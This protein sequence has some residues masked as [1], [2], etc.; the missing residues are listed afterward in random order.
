MPAYPTPQTGGLTVVYPV[1][2]A[3]S[4]K[5]GVL[6]AE[7]KNVQKS[8]ELLGIATQ[9]VKSVKTFVLS[10]DADSTEAATAV[11]EEACRRLLANPVVHDYTI[12]VDASGEAR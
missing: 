7:G 8:L 5:P 10:I 9:S 12:T 3:V 6:D 1:H 4:F 11:A 2:V